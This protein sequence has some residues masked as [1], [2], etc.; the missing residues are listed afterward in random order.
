MRSGILTG[1]GRRTVVKPSFSRWMEAT[2]FQNA[3]SDH[4]AGLCCGACDQI[5]QTQRKCTTNLQHKRAM[6]ENLLQL[7]IHFVRMQPKYQILLFVHQP[8]QSRHPSCVV[9]HVL[10]LDLGSSRQAAEE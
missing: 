5:E 9:V 7:Q 8:V 4:P 10:A 2:R 3:L 6:L 1:V